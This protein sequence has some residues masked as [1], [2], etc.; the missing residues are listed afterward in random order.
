[1]RFRENA[2]LEEVQEY[3]RGDDFAYDVTGCR[4]TE[5]SRG[6]AVAV[7]EL[8]QRKHYNAM[9]G[10][11]GGAIFTLADYALAVASNYNEPASV[12]VSN[13][14]EFISPAKGSRLVATC[15]VDKSGRSL[16]FYTVEVTDDTGRKVAKMTAT[17][18]HVEA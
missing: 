15:D 8:D 11:M 10:V 5:A 18:F 9:G 2:T 1:M 13:T 14:I 4:I 6:H 16:G 17:C 12:S 3:F 7:L